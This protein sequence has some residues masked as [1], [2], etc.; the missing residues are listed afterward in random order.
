MG[1]RKQGSG[2]PLLIS[3]IHVISGKV[4]F[5]RLSLRAVGF[6]LFAPSVLLFLSHLQDEI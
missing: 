1:K 6:A 5:Y 3:V 2:S 4:C